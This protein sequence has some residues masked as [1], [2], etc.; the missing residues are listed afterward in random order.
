MAASPATDALADRQR[1]RS[2]AV[3]RRLTGAG[4]LLHAVMLAGALGLADPD[5]G[6]HR[7]LVWQ[8]GADV[9][10]GALLLSPLRPAPWAVRGAAFVLTCLATSLDLAVLRPHD[11]VPLFYVWS[12]LMATYFG[13]GRDLVAWY[14]LFVASLAAALALSPDIDQRPWFAVTTIGSCGLVSF[15]VLRVRGRV[16]RL[17]GELEARAVR[18]DLTQIPNRRAFT[19]ALERELARAARSGLP[20]SVVLFDLDHFKRVNDRY[21]HAAG[22]QALRRFA[23]VLDGERRPGDVVARIGGEEF[24]ALLFDAPEQAA[25]AFARRVVERLVAE[26]AGEE[27]ALSTS[28]G[29]AQLGGRARTPEALMGAADRGLYAAKAAGRRRVVVAP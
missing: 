6:D 2:L 25:E 13:S 23:R 14:V 15:F 29:V 10:L 21:G 26:T 5:P 19:A 9:V 24:A 20:L 17:M 1:V 4:M 7:L 12:A 8:V 22:D 3:L 16:D 28:A 11:P 27:P 18:D